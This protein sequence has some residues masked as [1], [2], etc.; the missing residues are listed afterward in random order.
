MEKEELAQYIG[1]KIKE[2]RI[3][4]GKTQ[5]DLALL[6]NT[7]KQSIGRYENGSRRANQ[8]LLFELAD[9]FDSSNRNDGIYRIYLQSIRSTKKN[10][11]L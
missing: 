9:I 3:S 5:E 11:S 8:D 4:Q 6:L 7:T 1:N 10:K 2:M